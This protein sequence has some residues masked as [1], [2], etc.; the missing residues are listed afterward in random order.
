MNTLQ[1]IKAA[2]DSADTT[3]PYWKIILNKEIRDIV[4]EKEA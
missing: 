1:K 4:L 2:I 3:N